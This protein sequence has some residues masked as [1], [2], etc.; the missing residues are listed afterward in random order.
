MRPRMISASCWYGGS[1]AVGSIM[2]AE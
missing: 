1:L 2:T